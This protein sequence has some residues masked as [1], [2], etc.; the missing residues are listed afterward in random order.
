MRIL[1]DECLPV[2]LRHELPGHEVDTVS[3][4]GWASIKNGKLLRKIA[5]TG[6]F[7]VF[8][9][10]DKNLPLEQHVQNQPFAIVVLRA[11]TNK[12]AD[13]RPLLPE[14]LR[15][16]GEFEAGHVYVLA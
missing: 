15:R 3:H 13:V 1:L 9:T 12:I 16:V 10:A 14:F 6:R 7:D 5:D 11:R 8:L 4:A 2:R